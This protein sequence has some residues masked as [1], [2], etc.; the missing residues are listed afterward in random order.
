MGAFSDSMRGV[1]ESL[2]IEYGSE[3]T[4]I[5]SP[6]EP[7]IEMG[8]TRPYW[9]IEGVK[10]Y[11]PPSSARYAGYAIQKDVKAHETLDGRIR[12]T[13]M[14]MIAVRIPTPTVK[15]IIEWAGNKYTILHV[16]PTYVQG[17]I[18]IHKLYVRKS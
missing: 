6:P 2:I 8:T 10:S 9:M 14:V 7:Q 15:D 4:L 5:Q 16:I 18:V 13:D 11:I 17:N 1:S 12:I 3:I